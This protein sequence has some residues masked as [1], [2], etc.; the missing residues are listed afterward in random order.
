MLLIKDNTDKIKDFVKY[1]NEIKKIS[2]K[3]DSVT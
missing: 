2:L 3:N 1:N